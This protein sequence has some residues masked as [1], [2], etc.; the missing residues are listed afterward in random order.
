[1]ILCLHWRVEPAV[2]IAADAFSPTAQR[3]ADVQYFYFYSILFISI[4]F[5]LIIF[6]L[7]Y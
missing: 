5:I 6:I 2:K 3:W 1:M 4:Y 7:L